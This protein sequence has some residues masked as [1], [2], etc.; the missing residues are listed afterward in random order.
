MSDETVPITLV[1]FR[2]WRDQPKTVF[3]LFP[4]EPADYAGDFCDAYER[5]GGH[6]GADYYLCVEASD[7]VSAED[8]ADLKRELKQIGYRLKV[9]KRASRQHHEAR[10]ATARSLK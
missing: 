2:R 5:V 10:R 7:P 6:G 8:A 3:A 1:N 4:Q 9:I